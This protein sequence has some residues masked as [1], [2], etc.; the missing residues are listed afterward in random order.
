M[1]SVR[2]ELEDER[3]Y[4][5]VVPSLIYARAYLGISRAM[6]ESAIDQGIRIGGYL[7]RTSRATDTN[8]WELP[9]R[10][11]WE[12]GRLKLR[13]EVVAW[14]EDGRAVKFP[15]LADAA[16]V[17]GCRE[18]TI[19]QAMY[20][21]AKAGEWNWERADVTTRDYVEWH[22]GMPLDFK[23]KLNTKHGDGTPRERPS[24][25]RGL[26]EEEREWA[27]RGCRDNAEWREHLNKLMWENEFMPPLAD[28]TTDEYGI[29]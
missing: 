26:T 11:G 20:R 2:V 7:V 17:A 27:R 23:W 21:N 15:S 29:F 16:R 8:E 4:V 12:A 13:Q 18:V 9:R 10:K 22:P 24:G 5:Y 3:G 1:K 28:E 25:D 6:M 14:R 19:R